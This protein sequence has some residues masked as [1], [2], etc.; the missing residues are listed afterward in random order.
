[1]N[2]PLTIEI[3]NSKEEVYNR[4][5]NKN[6]RVPKSDIK[7]NIV[8]NEEQKLAKGIVLNNDIVLVKGMAGSGKT[9]LASQIALDMLFKREIE[10]IIITRPN[11]A[12]SNELGFL[13]G[14]IS[15]KMNPWLLPLYHNLYL[16]CGKEKID[17]LESEGRIEILPLMY[18]RGRTFTDSFIIIDECQNCTKKETEML[19]GR[20]GK[21]SRMTF[22]GDVSQ[23]DLKYKEQSG[24]DFFKI[25]KAN[26]EGVEIVDLK[27]NHRHPIVK[28]C[29]TVFETYA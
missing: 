28:A 17:K 23:I 1:M 18:V 2:T 5:P 19:I 21:G 24:I 14:D 4:T 13:P 9:L 7:Y 3:N 25:L 6:K 12:S 8:L 20:L 16:I 27:E 29:L 22:T 26:V 11:V 15:A 10:R